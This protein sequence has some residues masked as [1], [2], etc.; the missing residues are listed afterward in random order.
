MAPSKKPPLAS[1]KKKKARSK[2]KPKKR[3]NDDNN[4][5]AGTSEDPPRMKVTNPVGMDAAFEEGYD[6]DGW[7]GPP[8]GTDEK[9]M[10]L[11]DEKTLP[12]STAG[13][14]VTDDAQQQPDATPVHIPIAENEFN[15]LTIPM[16][17]QELVI[18]KVSLKSL[19]N[20]TKL[21]EKLHEALAHEL[22]VYSTTALE[23]KKERNKDKKKP[24]D[25]SCFAIGAVWKELKPDI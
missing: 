17:K 25:M 16:L 23:A 8:R 4:N 1:P 14:A 21:Q 2:S 6:T 19:T 18:R 11:A 15:K 12:E 9:E 7:E 13:C 5:S 3:N 20:K 10:E 24:D 22:P